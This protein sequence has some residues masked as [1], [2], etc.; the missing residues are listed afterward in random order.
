MS[1]SKLLAK[2][3]L[4]LRS[5]TVHTIIVSFVHGTRSSHLVAR[6]WK[7]GRNTGHCDTVTKTCKVGGLP[8]GEEYELWMRHCDNQIYCSLDAKPLN[9]ST[10]PARNSSHLFSPVVRFLVFK[11]IF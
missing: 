6:N 2:D 9:V 3:M 5:R 8:P 7:Y 1:V 10:R 11:V 4:T